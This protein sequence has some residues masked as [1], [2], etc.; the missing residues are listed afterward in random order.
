MLTVCHFRRQNGAYNDRNWWTGGSTERW[1]DKTFR[2][3]FQDILSGDWRRYDPYGLDGR[4]DA[5]TSVYGKANRVS[6]WLEN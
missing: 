1:E 6:A 4:L 5:R 2:K 3:C